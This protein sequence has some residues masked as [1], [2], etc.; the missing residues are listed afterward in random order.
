MTT[1]RSLGIAAVTAG[2]LLVAPVSALAVEP[3][4]APAAKK[5]QVGLDAPKNWCAVPFRA[6]EA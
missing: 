3:A 6:Y 1:F 4:G 5:P 2:A